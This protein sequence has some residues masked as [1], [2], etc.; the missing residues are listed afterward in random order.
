MHVVIWG[1]PRSGTS[2]TF[3]A[4][5]SHPAYRFFFEPGTWL[6]EQMNLSWPTVIKNPWSRVPTPGLSA[7]L[8]V[9]L[10]IEAKH[11]WVVRHPHDTV[12]SLRPGMTEQPHPP[13]LPTRWL[14]KP[15]IDRCAA[16][17][18]YCNETGLENLQVKVEVLTVRYEDLLQQPEATTRRMLDYASAEWTPEMDEYVSSISLDPGI[19]EAEFQRRWSREHDRHIGRK[20]LTELERVTIDNIVGE[21]PSYFGY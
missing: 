2:I 20:D 12:A 3:G 15:L 18:R 13:T 19:K 16:L 8:D 17:W 6:L 5:R 4:F 7:D 1:C 14:D 9:V 11:I 21:V 10:G